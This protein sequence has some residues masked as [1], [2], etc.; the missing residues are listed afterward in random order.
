MNKT[1]MLLV[2]LL[3]IVTL[4]GCMPNSNQYIDH[5]TGAGFWMGLWQ[6][7]IAP[8]SWLCSLFSDNINV[9]EVHNNGGW[10]NFGFCLGASIIFKSSDEASKRVTKR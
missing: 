8:I 1:L 9:Y 10:Y 5:N 3:T 7:W 2:I 6:G 4:S